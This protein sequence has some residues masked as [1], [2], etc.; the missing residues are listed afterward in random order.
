MGVHPGVLKRPLMLPT[1]RS[2]SRFTAAVDGGAQEDPTGPAIGA[3]R[4]LRGGAW[5]SRARSCASASRSFASAELRYYGIG[6]RVAMS[7]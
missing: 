6:F 2:M 7:R 4:S 3:A 1:S 5:Y